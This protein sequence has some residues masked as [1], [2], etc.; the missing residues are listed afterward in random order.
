MVECGF[1]SNKDDTM[2]LKDEKY[3]QKLA[4]AIAIGITDYFLN[5]EDPRF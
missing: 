2:N 1:L 4:F 3:Q 5:T